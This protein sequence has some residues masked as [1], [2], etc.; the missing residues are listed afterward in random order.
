MKQG[1]IRTEEIA[2]K[3][4][5]SPA[6][7]SRVIN[8]RNLVKEETAEKVEEAM[9]RLGFTPE[10]KL[11]KKSRDLILVNCPQGTNPFYEE[12][13]NGAIA[14]ADSHGY[15]IVLNYDFINRNTIGDFQDLLRKANVS[16]VILLSQ[17][18]TELLNAIRTVCP[19]VQ[20]CEYNEESDLPYVAID[21]YAAA[22]SAVNFLIGAGRNK[23][24]MLNG[25]KEYKYARERLRG[26]QDAMSEAELTVPASWMI[27]VPQINY[28]MALS[29]MT[30][31][32]R[33]DRIPNAIFAASDVLAAAIINAA[34][35]LKLR[36]PEDLMV[37]GFDNIQLSHMM[38]PT[39]TT[40]NQPKNQLGFTACEILNDE[41]SGSCGYGNSMILSTE[42]IIRES[43]VA[44]TAQP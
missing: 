43:A 8:H 41:I 21:N 4:G 34:I 37:V 33:S 32:L 38:R 30:R 18:S 26:F 10:V 22:K 3:A 7:V 29:I 5:V 44:G 39:I 2:R 24:A 35:D 6:T 23:V 17:L 15:S 42:L 13:I 1:K 40:I 20:C 19:I 11:Q 31:F 16:G 27:E 36:V 9:Q 28:D 25:P 12:I 14:S